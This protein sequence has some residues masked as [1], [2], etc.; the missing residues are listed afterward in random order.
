LSEISFG[1][2]CVQCVR[3]GAPLAVSYDEHRRYHLYSVEDGRA[4][5]RMRWCGCCWCNECR[6][7]G[8]DA[9]RL[10]LATGVHWSSQ[11]NTLVASCT[12]VARRSRLQGLL[13]LRPTLSRGYAPL[14]ARCSCDPSVC[15][16][17][18]VF[19]FASMLITCDKLER[20]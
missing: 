18:C 10:R 4:D 17:V 1:R 20:Y 7:A 3:L 11:I 13:R 14:A 5:G 2:T 9:A 6:V 15:P 19:T 12:H 16:F 8:A